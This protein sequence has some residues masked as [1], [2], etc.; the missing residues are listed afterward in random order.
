VPDRTLLDCLELSQWLIPDIHA[1]LTPKITTVELMT[2][3]S[4]D[5]STVSRR[6]AALQKH[7]LLNASLRAGRGAYWVVHRV[8]PVA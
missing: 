6:I 5:Q 7:Q 8:G 1:G 3:W 2:W 4:C